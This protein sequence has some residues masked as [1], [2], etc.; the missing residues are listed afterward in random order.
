METGTL[1]S[2]TTVQF[3]SCSAYSPTLLDAVVASH[4]LL[5][6]RPP[7]PD[8]LLQDLVNNSY[9]SLA[10][11]ANRLYDL[12]LSVPFYT[13]TVSSSEIDIW[14]TRLRFAF[15]GVALGGIV[16]YLSSPAN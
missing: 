15:I 3:S 8:P 13:R 14:V 5:L 2:F 10:A 11:H 16:T 1:C 6:C 9:P 4:V 12:A 7:F